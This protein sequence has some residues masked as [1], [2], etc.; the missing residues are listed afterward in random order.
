MLI[1]HQ[2]TPGEFDPGHCQD[3]ARATNL[4]DH[5]WRVQREEQALRETRRWARQASRRANWALW[6][7]GIGIVVGVVALLAG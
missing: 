2:H 7:S 4:L 1:Q 3:C 5:Y 6:S